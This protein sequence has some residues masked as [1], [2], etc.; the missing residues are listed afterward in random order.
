MVRSKLIAEKPH[1]R[2]E[3]DQAVATVTG[4]IRA[5]A[6]ADATNYEEGGP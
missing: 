5:A 6:N 4:D 1:I 3:I 2:R